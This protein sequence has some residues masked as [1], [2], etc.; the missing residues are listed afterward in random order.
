MRPAASR[1]ITL[2]VNGTWHE[3]EVPARRTLAELLREELR[4]TGTKV[5]CNRA[6]CERLMIEHM[7]KARLSTLNRILPT[8][9]I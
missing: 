8:G 1:R 3:L 6:E 2:A 9:A 7:E 4:L 5:G